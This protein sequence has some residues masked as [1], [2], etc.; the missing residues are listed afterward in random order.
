GRDA[1]AA[2]PLGGDFLQE[3]I[4]GHLVQSGQMDGL[5]QVERFDQLQHDERLIGFRWDRAAYLPPVYPPFY[6]VLVSPLARLDFRKACA[7]WAALL[8]TSLVVACRLV[9]P[10][11]AYEPACASLSKANRFAG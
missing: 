6:Y 8:V 10:R 4:G 7:A 3:W 5:Y 9:A 2:T 11:L 1:D